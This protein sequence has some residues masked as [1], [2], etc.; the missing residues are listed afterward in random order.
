MNKQKTYKFLRKNKFNI[1][2]P[3]LM[4]GWYLCV[5]Y[6]PIYYPLDKVTQAEGFTYV[7]TSSIIGAF[8]IALKIYINYLKNNYSMKPKIKQRVAK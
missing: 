1:L 3:F 5:A 6:M 4:C 8:I 2:F 7:Y